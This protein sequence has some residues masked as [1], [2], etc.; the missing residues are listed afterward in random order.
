MPRLSR[1][2]R[3]EAV[4]FSTQ[5]DFVQFFEDE[6]LAPV[7]KRFLQGW[8]I[9]R[10]LSTPPNG[11]E[12]CAD[13]FSLMATHHH[14]PHPDQV[15]VHANPDAALQ[16]DAVEIEDQVL[17]EV[18]PPSPPVSTF[19]PD[20]S[21]N[22]NLPWQSVAVYETNTNAI[23]G[24]I[25]FQAYDTF[26][27]QVRRLLG[28]R[29]SD[30]ATIVP[31]DTK[32]S[33][34]EALRITPLFLLQHTDFNHG[35]NRRA[36]LV[37]IEYHGHH[38]HTPVQ[39]ERF[40]IKLPEHLH[41]QH[42]LYLIRIERY[43]EAM[44]QRCLVW[45]K[46]RLVPKQSQQLIELQHGDYV[47]VAV[48]PYLNEEVPTRFAAEC[49]QASMTAR[50]TL[51]RY[52]QYGTDDE[53]IYSHHS[54]AQR[55]PEDDDM[56][57][58][59]IEKTPSQAQ[60]RVAKQVEPPQFS[61][62][63]PGFFPA[64]D[65]GLPDVMPSWF[66]S[67]L[68]AFS[69]EACVE[70]EDE[71]PVCYIDTWYLRGH[72]A[73][74]TEQTRVFRVTQEPQ[75]WHE[76]LRELWRDRIDPSWPLEMCWV[77]PVPI[78]L[79][80]RHRIGHI[81]LHQE[82]LP[83]L[84]PTLLT[85]EF[86]DDHSYI[87]DLA[88]GLLPNPVSVLQVRDLANLA[89]HCQN[90]RCTLR[91]GTHLW[92][93]HELRRL[94]AGDGFSFADQSDFTQELFQTW[95][96]QALFGPAMFERLLRV[97]TW[98]LN[99][100][101]VKFHDEQRTQILGDDFW[102]WEQNLI[103]TWRDFV[104]VNSDVE[105]VIVTLAPVT[106]TSPT[107][108]N[109]ILHQR[110]QPGEL[111]NLISVSDSAFLQGH[112]YTAAV[113]T[114]MPVT[115][116]QL[117]DLMGKTLVC[118]PHAPT[119]SCSCWYNG[120]AVQDGQP[121]PNRAGFSYYVIITQQPWE[122]SW[123]D[124]Y[125]DAPMRDSGAAASGHQH[126]VAFH[127]EE[128]SDSSELLQRGVRSSRAHPD[129][130]ADPDSSC[131]NGPTSQ[132]I[133][134][135][136]VFRAFERLDNHYFLPVYDLALI[137]DNH[138]AF[139]WLQYWWDFSR[140]CHAIYLYFDGSFKKPQ[141]DELPASAAV[142][143]FVSTDIGWLFAGALSRA[144]EGVNSAYSAELQAAIMTTKLLFD[145]YKTH[146][147]CFGW[148][149]EA[150]LRYDALTV[151]QQALGNWRIDSHPI[152]GK[153]LRDLTLLIETRFTTAI[154]YEHIPSHTGEPGNELVDLLALQARQHHALT[155][156]C[157]DWLQG[158]TTVPFVQ[159]ADW[160]WCL[161]APEF[162]GL[163]QGATM[164]HPTPK[165]MP[166]QNFLPVETRPEPAGAPNEPT[167]NAFLH[168]RLATCNVLSLKGQ[169]EESSG[170]PGISRQKALFRQL[171]EE[172]ITVLA[173][174]ETRLRRLHQHND[175]DYHLLKAEASHQGHF[176]I[177]MGF[178]KNFP[179]GECHDR[180]G[181]PLRKLYFQSHHFMILAFNPRYL[182]VR[183]MAPYLNLIIV[184]AHAPHSGYDETTIQSWRQEVRDQIPLQYQTWPI[185]VLCDANAIVGGEISP[186]IGGHQMTKVD[187]KAAAFEEFLACCD[188]RLP[189]T[190]QHHQQGE[191]HTWTHTSGRQ[192]RID[193][194]GIPLRWQTQECT[195]GISSIIDPTLLRNDHAAACVEVSFSSS[196]Q[197]CH[198]QREGQRQLRNVC[199]E[200]VD[201][202]SLH[203]VV[204]PCLDVHSHFH[205]VQKELVSCLQHQHGSSQVVYPQKTTMSTTT[206][207]L[208]CEKRSWRQTL[209][210]HNRAQRLATLE[211]TFAIW[212]QK[213][214]VLSTDFDSLRRAQDHLIAGALWQFRRLA[215][216][217]VVAVR[218]DDIE[219]LNS[220]LQ[221]GM[222]FLHPNQTKD[223]WRIIRR[224]I[225]KFKERR[226]GYRPSQL[227]SL[228]VDGLQHFSTLELGQE[229]DGTQLAAH[230]GH[231]QQCA[232]V[233]IP[234]QPALMDVP[235]LVEFE[236]ALRATQSD[237]STGYDQVPSKIYHY[238]PAKL[239]RLF[240][241]IML[242]AFLW[243]TEPLQNKEGIL[244]MIPKQAG[245]TQIGKFRGILLLPTLAKRMHAIARE[246]MMKQADLASQQFIGILE[247][248][249][250][251]PLLLRFLRAAH[252]STW[253]TL[254]GNEIIHTHR[255]TR[256]GSPIADAIFHVLMS[257]IAKDIR[258]WYHQQDAYMEVLRQLTLDP[259]FIV[260]SD[261]A[262][263]LAV[264]NADTLVPAI[265]DFMSMIHQQ[266]SRRGFLLNYSK[267]KTAAVLTFVGQGA[268]A[269]RKEHLLTS[270]PG[271]EVHQADG[272]KSWLHF[273]VS[274]RHLGVMFAA[275]HSLEPELRQRI[276]TSKAAFKNVS[277][278]CLLETLFWY[279][280]LEHSYHSTAQ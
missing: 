183:V 199:V 246:R 149:P 217:V 258:S 102:N 135:E 194:V 222:D 156:S 203:I 40:V 186:H 95:D 132:H 24:R 179:Y 6:N 181:Q 223:L 270:C 124:D 275:S 269:M 265:H 205:L 253:F 41:Q 13:E 69:A 70:F 43:C 25:L 224:A 239:G 82:P 77:H 216:A 23:R 215:R 78:S 242:K 90:R 120:L 106:A 50:E 196:M 267:G 209:A 190:F 247:A 93:T 73:Y 141:G 83:Y 1:T 21:D 225:P 162:A 243:G 48:P 53:S 128:E 193:Y 231:T 200:H 129:V 226:I 34:L 37:D 138:V 280:R 89:R 125:E 164:V 197:S 272:T 208:V 219:F 195:A 238:F 61:R 170:M 175:E 126:H 180:P 173:L 79:A 172:R 100:L 39:T 241:H 140:P 108:I 29:H 157:A 68:E 113:V 121:F 30:V 2:S 60:C 57:L 67:L 207:D 191:G 165:A 142:A 122:H 198:R 87:F 42:L 54:L 81:I 252:S 268:P 168:L 105:F 182:I 18:L 251:D 171:V 51:Q 118:P 72:H 101:Y 249:S 99:G 232:L 159:H 158:I 237:R 263:P 104:D 58:L 167:A 233:R 85:I 143:A 189:A 236:A 178:S 44:R 245:A 235:S 264:H 19:S 64:R 145:I 27:Q 107:E 169:A 47:R 131:A 185:A 88:A 256:P 174:Q 80:T 201:L 204:P 266:F 127:E 151:G 8:P 154:A 137:P 271:I 262:L 230:C 220:L 136:H 211:Q 240:Y 71:G 109:I 177:M 20:S 163:W 84:S 255:G 91:H 10:T 3:T 92:G 277:S 22:D 221:D 166:V 17:D 31:I 244:H 116:Q 123:D 59:Q 278:S 146:E 148:I 114:P 155:P 36:I 26:F 38:F 119:S 134:F 52:R 161:F 206:W 160:L 9:E 214:D 63:A 110:V 254:T 274:Y 279:R 234:A 49:R 184:A 86:H 33:D 212:K 5:I 7:Q 187:P 28:Y 248:L 94:Q 112:P 111:P 62:T 103:Q 228:E 261:F 259:V 229:V 152:P 276:G 147:A 75:Y 96:A 139:P 11:Q 176:G 260:W 45:H 144:L 273:S 55:D 115:K 227:L 130:R 76:D 4:T 150:V 56:R 16:E 15:P 188:V 202:S 97:Q 32:P 65:Q 192:R 35:D 210:E 218:Q 12:H 133:D 46:G 117:I 74:V 153:L 66:A 213:H 14:E 257:E 250:L 98:F